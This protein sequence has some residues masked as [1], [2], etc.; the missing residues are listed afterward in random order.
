MEF[1]QIGKTSG[2]ETTPYEVTKYKSQKVLE[3]VDE[4]LQER[5]K[6]WGY[7]SVGEG[8]FFD[9]PHCEYKYGKLLNVLPADVLSKRVVS[10]SAYGGWSRMDYYIKVE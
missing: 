8:W 1:R 10:V 2:D 7:I 4:I 9:I 6:E 3:L 5:P